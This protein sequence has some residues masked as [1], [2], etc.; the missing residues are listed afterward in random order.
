MFKHDF[1]PWYV[2]RANTWRGNSHDGFIQK[3]APQRN[4]SLRLSPLQQSI[5]H[6]LR[7]DCDVANVL[8]TPI[9][10]PILTW[11]ALYGPLASITSEVRHLL[12]RLL[13]VT[14]LRGMGALCHAD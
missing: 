11:Y 4:A 6:W 3:S 14:L 12:R 2:A 13:S 7:N 1:S 8:A 5:L 9:W 10:C